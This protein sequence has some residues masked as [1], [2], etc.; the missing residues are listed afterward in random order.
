MQEV[1]RVVFGSFGDCL[2]LSCRLVHLL[3]NRGILAN[4]A[5]AYA[6]TTCSVTTAP[7]FP[8]DVS[9]SR[10]TWSGYTNR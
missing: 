3:R 7:N 4:A 10:I 5:R 1:A 2:A 9:N 6:V 8:G